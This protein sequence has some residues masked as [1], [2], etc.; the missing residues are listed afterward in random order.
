MHNSYSLLLIPNTAN[1]IKFCFIIIQFSALFCTSFAIE[2]TET[3]ELDAALSLADILNIKL[4]TGSFLELNLQKSPLSITVIEDY[5]IKVSGARNLSELLDIF[6]PGFVYGYNKWNGTIWGMRGVFNDRNTK[7]L[8][9]VNG[10]K[11][12]PQ[13]RDGFQAETMLGP[14]EDIKRV[15]V[16][17]GP[18]SLAYGSGA[19]AGIINIIT[20]SAINAENNSTISIASDD[21]KTL[22]PQA[23]IY[24]RPDKNNFVTF[25]GGFRKSDGIPEAKT[26]IYG[27]DTWPFPSW[28]NNAY[29]PH[30]GIP[31]DG[32]YD[33]PEGNWRISGEWDYKDFLKF[34]ARSTHQAENAGAWFPFNPWPGGIDSNSLPA[35]L[36]PGTYGPVVQPDDPFWSQ[37]NSGECSRN[38]YNIDNLASDLEFDIPIRHNQLT[39]RAGFDGYADRSLTENRLSY[40][41]SSPDGRGYKNIQEGFGEFRYTFNAQYLL[42]SIPKLQASGGLSWETDD[43]GNGLFCGNSNGQAG[44]YVISPVVYTIFSI[45]AE[46]LYDLTDKF[47]ME[48]GA[49]LDLHTRATLLNGKLAFIYSLAENQTVKLIGQ[50]ASNYGSDDNYEYNRFHYVGSN[51]VDQAGTA[52]FGTALPNTPPTLVTPIVTIPSLSDMHSLKPEQS[53]SAELDYVGKPFS[54]LTVI[55]SL[56]ATSIQNLISWDQS[57]FRDINCN[58]YNFFN[59]ELEVK[60]LAGPFEIDASHTFTRLFATDVDKGNVTRHWALKP[61]ISPSDAWYDSSKNIRGSWDYY[62]KQ[63]YLTSIQDTTYL[64]KTTISADGKKFKNFPSNMTKLCVSFTPWKFVTLHTNARIWWGLDGR[65]GSPDAADPHTQMLSYMQNS[66]GYTVYDADTKPIVKLDA[67]LLFHVQKDF[68]VAINV[69]NILGWDNGPYSLNGQTPFFVRNTFRYQQAEMYAVSSMDQFSAGITIAKEF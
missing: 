16:L 23:N 62:P 9:L 64:V 58:G 40:S 61:G 31:S 47:S 39:L 35:H 29:T 48:G 28:V 20:K 27:L 4:T 10:H 37:D 63:Q 45:V 17:R 46:G 8:F 19:I 11:M 59:A 3:A 33:N 55:P 1:L 2:S 51:V 14:L 5:K 32:S 26:N 24:L 52:K 49:R 18:A 12:N 50:T 30:N 25:S 69:Y 43:M 56:S 6:V 38:Q 7:I 66:L 13:S 15:E 42:K 36:G 54:M 53:Y 44:Y 57:A 60:Y 67:N 65:S 68:S 41:L 22:E 34:Y 21:R